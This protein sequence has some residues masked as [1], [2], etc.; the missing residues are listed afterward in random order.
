MNFQSG[1]SWIQNE[2]RD[3]CGNR[4]FIK[5]QY[6]D[7]MGNVYCWGYY[8][9][10]DEMNE[11]FGSHMYGSGAVLEDQTRHFKPFTMGLALES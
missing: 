5:I 8:K 9:N 11:D 6:T 3:S 1:Q 7:K 4:D 10:E 2:D